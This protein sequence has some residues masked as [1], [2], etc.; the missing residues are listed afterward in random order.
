MKQTE[1]L[2]REPLLLQAYGLL[3]ER[4]GSIPHT[5]VNGALVPIN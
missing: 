5:L 2:R 4:L 1:Y 3:L